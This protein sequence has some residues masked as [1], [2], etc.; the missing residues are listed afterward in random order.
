MLPMGLLGFN[1]GSTE[2]T[3]VYIIYNNIFFYND[4]QSLE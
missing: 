2:D 1:V 3:I 4:K